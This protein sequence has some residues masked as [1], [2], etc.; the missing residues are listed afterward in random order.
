M[1]RLIACLL[2]L[3]LLLTGCTSVMYSLVKPQEG[4]WVPTAFEDMVYVRPDPQVLEEKLALVEKTVATATSAQQIMDVFEP[5]YADYTDFVTQYF[6]AYIHFC[7]DTTNDYW[8]AEYDFCLEKSTPA[9]ADYDRLL[10]TLADCPYREALEANEDWF[11]EGFFDDFQGESI[12]D[13][14]LEA[15]MMQEDQLLA[16][17][18]ELGQD[19]FDYSDAWFSTTGGEMEAIFLELVALR[20][21]IAEYAGYPD[22]PSFA[23]DYTYERDYTPQQALAY[24][25]QIQ[26]QLAPLYVPAAYLDLGQAG[27]CTQVQSFAYVSNVAQGMGGVVK[28][29]FELMKEQKLYDIVPSNKKYAASFE[30]F[31]YAYEEPFVFIN[32]GGTEGDK[33]T[34]THEFGHFCNDYASGGSQVGVDVAEV[35]SQGLEYLSLSFLEDSQMLAKRKIRDGLYTYVE[36]AAYASFEQQVYGLKGEDLTVENIRALYGK[37]MEDFGLAVWGS[38]SREYVMIHH[39]FASALYVISYVVS[40]DAALQMYQLEQAQ[41][42]KGKALYE[43]CLDTEEGS[44]MAFLQEAGLE[45]PFTAERVDRVR[46]T[47]E[48]ELMN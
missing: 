12:M 23:F 29:A 14:T 20:Q 46:K 22:Y 5:Y 44:F 10:Y 3:A 15:M 32:P 40:N 42:G 4:E 24:T 11:G 41:P 6:L 13:E 37:T 18:Y 8:R 48:E 25:R 17:Y 33:L 21:Q 2:V 31:L 39:F 16:Q 9:G 47:F 43:E 28:E 38:D 45:S 26:E 34:F 19:G 1:K 27:I 7:Q 36:Q 30:V 35:F